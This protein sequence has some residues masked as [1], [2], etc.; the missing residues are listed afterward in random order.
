MLSVFLN[1]LIEVFMDTQWSVYIGILQEPY[2]QEPQILTTC[3]K[4]FKK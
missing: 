2:S 3:Y 1:V 4:F